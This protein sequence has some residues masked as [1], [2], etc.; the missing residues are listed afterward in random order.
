MPTF[1]VNSKMNFLPSGGADSGVTDSSSFLI[2]DIDN[3]LAAI[4]IIIA[5]PIIIPTMI[6]LFKC[7]ASIT[8]FLHINIAKDVDTKI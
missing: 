5:T 6:F 7:C 8:L 1:S 2:F 4:P 3:T